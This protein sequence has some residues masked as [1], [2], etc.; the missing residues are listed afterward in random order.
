MRASKA[1]QIVDLILDD[2][3]GR[4]GYDNL[5]DDLDEEIQ[6]EIRESL[7]EIL[8]EEAE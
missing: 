1:A 7:T 6:D 2:L 8:V 5:W 4:S 3:N